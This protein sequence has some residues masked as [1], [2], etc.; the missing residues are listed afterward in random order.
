MIYK[1]K[2]LILLQ[3]RHRADNEINHRMIERLE[4]GTWTTVRWSELTVGDIIKV[5]IDTFFPADLILLSS[6]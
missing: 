2:Y 5:V 3:K 6:R 4:N 1:Y